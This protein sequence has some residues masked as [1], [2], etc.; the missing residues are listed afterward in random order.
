MVTGLREFEQLNAFPPLKGV[1]NYP[2]GS[3][4]VASWLADLFP[5][6]F[7]NSPLMTVHSFAAL[8]FVSYCLI[9][10]LVGQLS[11][12]LGILSKQN[13]AM[14]L[15]MGL[16]AQTLLLTSFFIKNLLLMFSLSFIT[17]LATTLTL[18]LIFVKNLHSRSEPG[19]VQPIIAFSLALIVIMNTYQTF[20][21][22]AF[23][24][25]VF[26]VTSTSARQVVKNLNGNISSQ[27]SLIFFAF[28]LSLVL[29]QL[30]LTSNSVA[31]STTSRFSL[32][33]H[34]IAIDVRLVVVISALSL[35]ILFSKNTRVLCATFLI[36]VFFTVLIS[37]WLSESFS[38]AYGLN[39]YA[40]KSEYMLIVLLVPMATAGLGFLLRPVFALI[41]SRIFGVGMSLGLIAICS[42]CML[43]GPYFSLLKSS[44]DNTTEERLMG[45]AL[46]E[47]GIG[48]RSVV[49]NELR[50]DISR[51]ASLMS[52]YVDLTSWVEPDSHSLTYV[53]AQQLSIHT[54]E[55]WSE[56]CS[57]L[58]SR[59]FGQ[60]RIVSVDKGL[61]LECP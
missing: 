11:N 42:T 38:R 32:V 29:V 8:L 50:P 3:H 19:R 53:M 18:L 60:G 36:S 31:A 7:L 39:Y 26:L 22:V 56:S 25:F 43:E 9:I 49:W 13:R 45:L 52:N 58:W 34:I 35:G 12:E 40:K 5:S 23:L 10:A 55:P 61:L 51:N 59:K 16:V 46:S 28:S 48:G 17:A 33:G 20:L 24:M 15:S 14:R 47:A 37:W 57:Y 21:F 1:E 54:G 6:S 41:P 2:A 30:T 27:M 4:Y 44:L